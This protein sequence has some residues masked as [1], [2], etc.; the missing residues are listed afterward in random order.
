MRGQSHYR[1]VEK[2]GGNQGCMGP[3]IAEL[4]KD[5][6]SHMNGKTVPMLPC[7]LWAW[8][9]IILKSSEGD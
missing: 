1:V 2:S 4:R 9:K 3:S 5:V 6:F 7:Q 8:V